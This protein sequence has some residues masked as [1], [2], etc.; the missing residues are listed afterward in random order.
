MTLNKWKM[1]IKCERFVWLLSARN[2]TRLRTFVCLESSQ[3][4]R[5]GCVTRRHFWPTYV[6]VRLISLRKTH[7]MLV[8]CMLDR[9]YWH[10]VLKQRM[11]ANGSFHCRVNYG[12][13]EWACLLQH[14][15]SSASSKQ[16]ELSV[17]KIRTTS[18]KTRRS[19][20][21]AFGDRISRMSDVPRRHRSQLVSKC[22]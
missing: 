12:Q 8:G 2:M 1:I 15:R 9:D 5:T 3:N 20:R 18:S 16:L 4:Q 21:R 17:L 7:L 13:A 22:K 19:S 14:L 10:R 6:N 11:S